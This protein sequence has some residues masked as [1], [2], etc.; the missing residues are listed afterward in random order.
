MNSSTFNAPVRVSGSGAPAKRLSASVSS[1]RVSKSGTS[2]S[3][4]SKSLR[5][6]K[7]AKPSKR[8]SK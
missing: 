1:V 4:P 3:V 2:S 8:R 6:L 5:G 7:V